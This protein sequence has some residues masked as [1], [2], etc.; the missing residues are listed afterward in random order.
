[1]DA[2]AWVGIA[3]IGGTVLAA[4]IGAIVAPVIAEKMGRRSARI[5]QILS[6]RMDAYTDLLRIAAEKVDNAR[7]WASLPL[8]DL[9]ETDDLELDNIISRIR[10]VASEP[11]HKRT[12][13]FNT[14]VQSFNRRL[15]SVAQ[16]AQRRAEGGGGAGSDVVT[17]ERVALAE[18]AEGIAADYWELQRLIR[19]EIAG[20]V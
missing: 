20:R 6:Q 9:G 4:A 10:V 16:P 1:M 3:G 8:V 2:T 7:A 14:K 17:R 18:I 5:N 12:A 11:V 15:V 13:S 19:S